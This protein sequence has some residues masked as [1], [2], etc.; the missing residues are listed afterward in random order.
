MTVALKQKFRAGLVQMRSGR[1]VAANVADATALIEQAAA[2]GAQYVQTPEVTTLMELDRDRLFAQVQPEAGN[3][4][5]AQF[6]ALAQRLQ[7][8]L[9]VGSMAVLEGDRI[10]NRSYVMAPDGSIAA[11]YDK[12]HMFDV[13]LANGEIYKESANYV[14]GDKAVLADLPWGRL[15]LTIC[16]DLRFPALHQALVMGGAQFLSVPAAFTRPTGEAHWHTLVR[17]RAI[18]TQ[19]FVFAAAQG[20]RHEHGRE[21]YGHSLIVS[22]WGTVLAEGGV[23]PG[24]VIADIDLAELEVVRARIPCLEHGRAFTLTAGR[25][26][27]GRLEVG[28]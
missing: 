21:T 12:I 3:I 2:A 9:H 13:Q 18:E 20:G 8:W 23:D 11:R 28:S 1:D 14:P 4:A 10:A 16:Y 19:C 26:E 22:P 5:L 7:I 24:V 15:G 17:A 25:L 27:V 6:A